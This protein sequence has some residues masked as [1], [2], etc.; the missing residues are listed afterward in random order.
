MCI[1]AEA[2]PTL[3]S[4]SCY[5]LVNFS[6]PFCRNHGIILPSYVYDTP[7]RQINRNREITRDYHIY[8][9]IGAS[10]LSHL[11][12]EDI[13]RVEKCME[14]ILIFYCRYYFPRCDQT[15]S[16]F[17]RQKV[18][19]ESCLKLTHICGEMWKLFITTSKTRSPGSKISL[20]C[21]LQQYRNAGDSPE[22]WYIN[23][24]ANSTGNIICMG[25]WWK[26]PLTRQLLALII[27][28]RVLDRRRICSEG[29]TCMINLRRRGKRQRTMTFY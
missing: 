10:K 19:H 2:E 22:C 3:N 20:S 17:K 14:N 8:V 24:L 12:K 5:P 11:F 15:Q 4:S 16:V 9:M 7:E 21:E 28:I 13:N 29:V 27:D 26:M 25:N 18:C 23:T 1:P 6:R